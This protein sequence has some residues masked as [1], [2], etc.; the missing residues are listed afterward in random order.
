MKVLIV[1]SLWAA[2]LLVIQYVT[3][4]RQHNDNA[5]TNSLAVQ[6]YLLLSPQLGPN[7]GVSRDGSSASAFAKV[8]VLPFILNGIFGVMG[9]Y[10]AVQFQYSEEEITNGGVVPFN[11]VNMANAVS[12][13]NPVQQLEAMGTTTTMLKLWMG[14]EDE[15]FDADK[16]KGVYAATEIADLS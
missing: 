14:Q 10:P 9:H 11:M 4:H 15:L 2:I 13:T 1:L 8:S 7:A 12:P 3:A 5:S 16:V 6:G